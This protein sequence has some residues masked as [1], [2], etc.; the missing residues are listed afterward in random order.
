MRVYI[1]VYLFA[2]VYYVIKFNLYID[3]STEIKA[4]EIVVLFSS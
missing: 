3:S 2:F 4:D 1:Y